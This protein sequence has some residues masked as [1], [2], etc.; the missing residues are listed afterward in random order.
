M[1]RKL[2]LFLA[3]AAVFT[4]AGRARPQS[5]QGSQPGK[6]SDL[7][8]VQEKN[9]AA[10][11]ANALIVQIN[12]A[13]NNKQWQQAEDLLKQ[14]IAAC[15]SVWRYQQA[16]GSAQLNL[17]QYDAA[18]QTYTG[19]IK[20]AQTELDANAPNTDPQVVKIGIAQMLT[21]EGS[22]YLKQKRKD[23]AIEEYTKATEISPNPGLA[24]FNLCAAQYKIGNR[25]DA[26]AAC[27]KSIAADPNM[28]DA[29]FIIGSVLYSSSL[30]DPRGKLVPP[31]GTIEAIEE[32]LELA[33]NGAHATEAKQMLDALEL[34]N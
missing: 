7:P 21:S 17:R 22:A 5:G 27:H 34:R 2:A 24:Y 8:T 32:Y 13:V 20:L 26:L 1:K 19:A 3:L 16:L 31:P 23:L 33:P 9:A 12:A 11:A 6:D 10:T 18:I 30:M 15:P 4:V 14:L 25:G 28:A 29:Y